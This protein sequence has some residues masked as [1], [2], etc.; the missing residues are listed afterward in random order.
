MDLK[1]ELVSK[2]KEIRRVFDLIERL[3]PVLDY[4]QHKHTEISEDFMTTEQS[5]D[6]DSGGSAQRK[7]REEESELPAPTTIERDRLLNIQEVSGDSEPE[8]SKRDTSALVTEELVSRNED[9]TPNLSSIPAQEKDSNKADKAESSLPDKTTE[10]KPIDREE[11]VQS[12]EARSSPGQAK[13]AD[14]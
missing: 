7:Q 11:A 9:L 2:N 12:S 1:K 3:E 10:K 13:P 4:D 14:T 6:K 5:A 8:R